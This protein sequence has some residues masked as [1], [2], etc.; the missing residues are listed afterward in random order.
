[1]LNRHRC[2]RGRRGSPRKR[3]GPTVGGHCRG[4]SLLK[5]QERSQGGQRGRHSASVLHHVS[6]APR[7]RPQCVAITGVAGCSRM[8]TSPNRCRRR[9]ETRWPISGHATCTTPN[10]TFWAPPSCCSS[11]LSNAVMTRSLPRALPNGLTRPSGVRPRIGRSPRTDPSRAF[12]RP[13]RPDASRRSK[14]STVNR[15]PERSRI[16]LISGPMICGIGAG[17][18]EFGGLQ[19]QQT[20]EQRRA[21]GV[22]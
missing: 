13:T 7:A 4:R 17:L 10:R 14:V 18:C 16:L 15:M 12:P 1:M 20:L 3:H 22:D 5:G 8:S 6:D 2:R 11:V 9:P 19:G 21:S